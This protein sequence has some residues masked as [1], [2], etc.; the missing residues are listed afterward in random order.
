M[1]CVGK[2]NKIAEYEKAE[3]I[4]REGVGKKKEPEIE[5]EGSRG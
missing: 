1:Q 3:Q 2:R 4:K 5:Y